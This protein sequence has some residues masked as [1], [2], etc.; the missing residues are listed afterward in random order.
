MEV[1]IG[2][3]VFSDR[4]TMQEVIAI[5]MFKEYDLSPQRR[6][7]HDAEMVFFNGRKIKMTREELLQYWKSR[8]SGKEDVSHPLLPG[9][10]VINPWK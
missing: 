2:E 9:E 6:E 1:R 10:E 8:M 4:K 3:H 5:G 7:A